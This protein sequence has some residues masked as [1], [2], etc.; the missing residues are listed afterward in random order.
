MALST[1]CVN[2]KDNIWPTCEALKESARRIMEVSNSQGTS[3]E[4]MPTHTAVCGCFGRTFD[5][6]SVDVNV[7]NG[8]GSRPGHSHIRKYSDNLVL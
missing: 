3:M 5:R 4:A 2:V 7:C 1:S 8:A 6:S